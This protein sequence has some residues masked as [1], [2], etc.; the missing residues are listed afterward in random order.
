[1]MLDTL[2]AQLPV[3]IKLADEVRLD[4]TLLPNT[5]FSFEDVRTQGA[6]MVFSQAYS[7]GVRDG[8]KNMWDLW[9]K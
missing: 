2:E 3:F 8:E 4:V 5:Q 1:M 6:W 7:L 9:E